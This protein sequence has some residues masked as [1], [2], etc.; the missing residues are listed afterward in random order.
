MPHTAG[1]MALCLALIAASGSCILLSLTSD[2]DAGTV[3]AA[4]GEAVGD[5]IPLV[6]GASALGLNITLSPLTASMALD[7]NSTRSTLQGTMTV[8]GSGHWRVEVSAAPSDGYPAEFDPNANQYVS[9]GYKLLNPMHI[10]A[11]KNDTGEWEPEL[12]LSTGGDLISDG[13]G[14]KGYNIYLYET[15]SLE[16]IA[17][18]EGHV[19][20]ITLTFVGIPVS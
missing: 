12:D 17:L 6:A 4:P 10:Q 16:D 9:G 11:Q 1:L 2:A 19:Y 20:R 8:R 13:T 15:A 14:E 3:Q 7:P 18:Q 5:S